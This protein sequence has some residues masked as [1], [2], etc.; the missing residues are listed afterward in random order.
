M[1]Y[2]NYPSFTNSSY[3]S[4]LYKHVLII[5]LIVSYVMKVWM[6]SERNENYEIFLSNIIY[7]EN[8]NILKHIMTCQTQK[9][10]KFVYHFLCECD[11]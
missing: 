4:K 10:G 9:H 2:S 6:S 5:T 8:R 1:I 7:D 11:L 3:T